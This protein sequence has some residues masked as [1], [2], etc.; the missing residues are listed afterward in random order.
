ML[1]IFSLIAHPGKCWDES[2][3]LAF[4]PGSNYPKGECLEIFCNEDFSLIHQTYVLLNK[5]S[6]SHFLLEFSLH[7]DF[8]NCLLYNLVHCFFLSCSCG[9]VA[10]PGYHNKIDYSKPYP[11]CCINLIKD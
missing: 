9:V 10:A 1:H 5:S 7:L 4:E 2:R 11:E 3:K 6:E 8:H